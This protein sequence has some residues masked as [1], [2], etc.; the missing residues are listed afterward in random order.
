[1]VSRQGFPSTRVTLLTLGAVFVSVIF[2]F[3]LLWMILGSFKTPAVFL[4][5]PPVWWFHPTVAN[6]LEVFRRSDFGRYLLNSTIVGTAATAF[7]LGLGVPAAYAIARYR[8]TG[9]GLLLLMALMAP[10]ISFAIPLFA[11]FQILHLGGSHAALIASHLIIT[12]PLV[13]WTMVGFI[14]AVPVEIEHAALVDGCSIW[15]LLYKIVVPLTRQGIAASAI[16][17][18]IFSW[19]NFLFALVLS[20]GST[21]T[22]PVAVSS[23]VGYNYIDWGQLTAAA[24]VIT[25]PVLVLALIVQRHIVKGLTAGG[26]MG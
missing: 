22:L 10:G 14:E 11:L 18:F 2:L 13:V 7:G 24:S 15:R 17:A 19:N 8:R 6:Y 12:L 4:S 9:V 21:K 26:I 16:L 23:Y 1:M 25:M 5:Y 3:P 20:S